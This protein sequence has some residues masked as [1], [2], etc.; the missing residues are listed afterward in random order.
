MR[1][2]IF[3]AGIAVIA[4]ACNQ[5]PSSSEKITKRFKREI[6]NSDA[7]SPAQN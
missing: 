4:L 2:S 6:K 1:I 3:T 7:I 5:K